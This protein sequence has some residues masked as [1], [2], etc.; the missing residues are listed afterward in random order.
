MGLFRQ[1]RTY[2]E[3]VKFHHTVFALPFAILSAFLAERGF[4][5]WPKF[6]WI[7]VAMVGARSA[8]MAFNRL[9]DEKFDRE[10][11]R[12]A[13]RHLPQGLV[14]R[15]EVWLFTGAS[16]ALFVAA[17][18][19]LNP[20]TFALSPVALA[21][22]LGYSFSKRFTS[23]SHLWLGL[24]LSIAPVGAWI[25]VTGRFAMPPLWL[26]LAVVLW[27]AGFDI[28]YSCMDYEFDVKAGL[29]SIPS[30]LGIE[31]SLKVSACLHLLALFALA[32]FLAISGLG[33]FSWVGLA[34]VAG[35]LA[36][37]HRIV[38]PD[39]L[40]RVNTAF[41]AVNAVISFGTMTAGLLDIYLS[42]QSWP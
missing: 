33:I 16:A 23:L 10:N 39:D 7:L 37:E 20:L 42:S 32:G 13:G 21:V 30:R 3:L 28:L 6:A 18:Y 35:L 29:F 8:A 36:Y 12:T 24:A 15:V 31:R 26:A 14:K 2:C 1:V 4:P 34:S 5:G 25:A 38:R 19:A 17:T 9:M 11:P 41:F 27:T 22:I 40:R